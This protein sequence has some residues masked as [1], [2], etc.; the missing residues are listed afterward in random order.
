MVSFFGFGR[1]PSTG[2]RHSRLQEDQEDELDAA[3]GGEADDEEGDARELDANGEVRISI[4]ER[5][6]LHRITST[7]GRPGDVVDDGAPPVYDSALTDAAANPPL[8][9]SSPLQ[10]SWRDRLTSSLRYGRLATADPDGEVNPHSRLAHHPFGSGMRND[11]V[12]ANLVAKP[13]APRPGRGA[14]YAGGDDNGEK[15]VPPVRLSPF[16]DVS[17]A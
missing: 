2:P 7:D 12:F 9:P 5:S 17:F 14:E 11:G 4:D 16:H 10:S 8:H 15:E 3:F 1:T 6:P 13:E